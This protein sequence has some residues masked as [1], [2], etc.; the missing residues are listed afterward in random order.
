VSELATAAQPDL[1]DFFRS[2]HIFSIH[3]FSFSFWISSQENE[4][5]KKKKESALTKNLSDEM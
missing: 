3:P 4:K 2:T 5:K 1:L